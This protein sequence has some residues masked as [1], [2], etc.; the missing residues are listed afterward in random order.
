MI[1]IAAGIFMKESA[2][3]GAGNRGVD[4]FLPGS[5]NPLLANMP[6]E[7]PPATPVLAP[8]QAAARTANP[9]FEAQAAKIRTQRAGAVMAKGF[10]TGAVPPAP[11]AAAKMAPKVAPRVPP[12]TSIAP[13]M[14]SMLKRIPFKL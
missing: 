1:R 13:K 5:E 8:L 2:Y 10:H 14:M 3:R 6:K 11:Q 4:Q 7:V 12:A 9:E